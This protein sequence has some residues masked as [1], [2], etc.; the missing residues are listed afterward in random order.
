MNEPLYS[1]QFDDIYFSRED[2]VAESRFVFLQGN[3]LPE[4]WAEK[5]HF[6]IA[7]TGFGTGLN[8]LL[9]WKL[10]EETAQRGHVLDY[11]SIEKYPLSADEI[12]TALAHWDDEFDGRLGQLQENYPMRI[13]GT[14]RLMLG[15]NVRLT[16]LFG[17][18]GEVLPELII[19]RGVDAWFLDG[20]APAKN[21]DMWSK[22]LFDEMKRLSAQGATVATFTAAGHVR[23]GLESAGFAV[24]KIKGYGRKRE[25]VVAE[26][27]GGVDTETPLNTK[28]VAIIG[29]AL[30]GA[31]CAY[32]LK[33]YGIEP[34]VFEEL[35]QKKPSGS[36]HIRG[37]YN[38]RFAFGKS[39]EAYFYNC[40]FALAY[41]TLKNIQKETNIGLEVCGTLHLFKEEWRAE[42][43]SKIVA[44]GIWHTDHL[45]ALTAKE[46]SNISGW[47]LD[48]DGV[49]LPDGGFVDPMRLG[50]AYLDGVEV[51]HSTKITDLEDLREEFDAVILANGIGVLDFVDEAILP[52]NTV[53]GQGSLFKENEQSGRLKCNVCYGGHISPA[54]GGAHMVGATFQKWRYD[55]EIDPVDHL[56][57]MEKL[58]G[59]LPNEPDIFC[60]D[61]IVGGRAGFRIA[62]KDRFPVSGKHKGNVYIS[63][64]QGSH[65]ILSSL[66]GAY[67]LADE[68]TGSVYSQ[69][70]MT[71][72]QLSPDRFML[73]NRRKM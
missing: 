5:P 11:V 1:K 13:E 34:V 43:L 71:V 46:A 56:E 73:R 45:Q 54:V 44:S 14:H 18:M 22:T 66:A 4:R 7:E 57:N 69:K 15:K 8:F 64:A 51:R 53:R 26:F 17:D 42:R 40:A 2:G 38:P 58:Q 19:P 25:M 28:R 10:F 49:Y 21:P 24:E 33:Q 55:T 29:G 60:E 35:A 37:M 30:S 6:T 32:V 16:L 23:R 59:A 72:K 31:T 65:G 68:M 50:M 27:G 3:N 39:P 47:N 12:G 62:T 20:F 9:T 61:D 48:A 36:S 52:M 63:T 70:K 41:R 67:L